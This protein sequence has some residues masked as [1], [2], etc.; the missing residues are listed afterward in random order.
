MTGALLLASQ[1]HAAD[2]YPRLGGVLISNPKNYYD[3]SYQADIAKLNVAVLGMYPGW[4]KDQ[5]TSPEQAVKQIKSRNPN[6]KIFL[7]VIGESLRY[8]VN[9]AWATLGKTVDAQR[10][11]LYGADG[12]SKVLS[13][14]GKDSYVL[15]ITPY[16]KPDANG[17]HFNQWFAN[18]VAQEM[19]ATTPS[20]DGLFT[21]NVFWK[22]RRDGDWNGDGKVDSQNSAT[23]QKYYRQGY[24]QYIDALRP[25][26]PGK[27]QIANVADWGRP[28]ADIT[29]YK[30]KWN[31]GII[32]H[33]KDSNGWDAMMA[34]YRKTMAAFAAPKL[35]L[36]HY[37]AD[38]KDYRSMRYGLASCLM[39]DGYFAFSNDNGV[40]SGVIWFDE[41][42]A[43][44][45]NAVSAPATKP[46]QKGVYRRDFENGIALVNPKGNGAQEV[47]LEEDFVTIKGKQ[48]PTVNTGQKVRKIRLEDRDGII[49]LRPNPVKRPAA[50]S[51]IVVESSS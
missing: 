19:G 4:G 5:G 23:V 25:R 32:E 15:N 11:W 6:T 36:F 44:L 18:H 46:W 33:I 7:Y 24:V 40:Y 50:P 1:A 48:A 43:K 41:F 22:P 10:W 39:D 42:D 31:G 8:P 45:G 38:P 49:L 30:G 14:F 51:G 16:S 9:P 12:K 29:E 35:G 26:M 21:D 28:Q 2:S 3:A 20:A 37:E 27:L 34:Q 17:L 13:D 47:T